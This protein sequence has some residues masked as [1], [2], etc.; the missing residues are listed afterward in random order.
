MKMIKDSE[1][2]IETLPKRTHEAYEK[3]VVF[4]EE[5]VAKLSLENIFERRNFSEIK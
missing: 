5:V 1:I 2:F 4:C 3:Y